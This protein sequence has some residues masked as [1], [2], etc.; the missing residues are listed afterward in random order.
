MRVY[1]TNPKFWKVEY[2]CREGLTRCFARRLASGCLDPRTSFPGALKGRARNPSYA[3]T[4]GP[5]DFR[6]CVLA[7]AS[8]KDGGCGD[9]VSINSNVTA[10]VTTGARATR[11]IAVRKAF[12]LRARPLARAETIRRPLGGDRFLTCIER[13]TKRSL[14]P[15]SGIQ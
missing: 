2:F 5:K 15:A 1:A 13:L 4:R 14:K 6:A 12:C 8:R 9:G 7:H 10:A 3:G 11:R